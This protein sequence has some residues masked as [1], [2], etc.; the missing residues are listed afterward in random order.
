MLPSKEES[1]LVTG[2]TPLIETSARTGGVWT[3]TLDALPASSTGGEQSNT[4]LLDQ[5]TRLT[6]SVSLPTR[7][8][9]R[10]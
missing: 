4:F 8:M 3:A 9:R 5:P 7:A 1:V 2:Q 6:G 10:D